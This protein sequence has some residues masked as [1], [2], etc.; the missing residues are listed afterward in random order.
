MKTLKKL[1]TGLFVIG[2]VG[3]C[4]LSSEEVSPGPQQLIDNL[5]TRNGPKDKTVEVPFKAK[6][7]SVRTYE[8]DVEGRCTGDEFS[9]FNVQ[10]GEGQATHLGR[11]STKM[12]FCVNPQTFQYKDGHGESIAANG[13]KLFF[14]IPTAGE[15]GQIQPIVHPLYELTFQDPFTFT[16]GTGRFEGAS[17]GGY[18]DSF[19]DLFDDDGNFILEHQTDHKWS[20]TLILKKPGKSI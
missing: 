13:D 7:F 5:Q 8:D 4:E 18:T 12:W 3:G 15:V 20:G 17:G 19:V 16:G 11:F 2:L 14:E 1:F 10:T 9:D 6:F